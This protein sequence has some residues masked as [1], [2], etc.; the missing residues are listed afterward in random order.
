M[1]PTAAAVGNVVSSLTGLG[2]G[3]LRFLF[4]GGTG[5]GPLL[6]SLTG[7]RP[8]ARLFD[9]STVFQAADLHTPG[10]FRPGFFLLLFLYPYIESTDAQRLLGLTRGRGLECTLELDEF[11]RM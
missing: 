10:Y 1:D 8:S 2:H 6:P 5:M 3:A 4:L 7:P 9:K 11:A